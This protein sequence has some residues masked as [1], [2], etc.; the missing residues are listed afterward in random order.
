MAKRNT[1]TITD[2]SNLSDAIVEAN[3]VPENVQ[4]GMSEMQETVLAQAETEVVNAYNDGMLSLDEAN[5]KLALLGANPIVPV[6]EGWEYAE[7]SVSDTAAIPEKEEMT[8]EETGDVM[9]SLEELKARANPKHEL[10]I[11]V[12]DFQAMVRDREITAEQFAAIIGSEY[13]E[14]ELEPAIPDPNQETKSDD[15]I[16]GVG[17]NNPPADDDIVAEEMRETFSHWKPLQ[18]F[19][20]EEAHD[21]LL[22]VLS[23][24]LEHKSKGETS[25]RAEMASSIDDYF[26][27]NG[28]GIAKDSTNALHVTKNLYTDILKNVGE[29]F[30]KE[31]WDSSFSATVGVAIETAILMMVG[32]AKVGYFV[33][34]GDRKAVRHNDIANEAWP[35][36]NELAEGA[37]VIK[38]VCVPANI[39]APNTPNIPLGGELTWEVN[40]NTSLFLLSATIS[41]ALYQSLWDKGGRFEVDALNHGRITGFLSGAKV[42]EENAR[43]RAKAEAD[44]IAAEKRNADAAAAKLAEANG[45]PPA[46]STGETQERATGGEPAAAEAMSVSETTLSQ[47]I[48][49]ESVSKD[50]MATLRAGFEKVILERDK[51][52]RDNRNLTEAA[53]GNVLKYVPAL[54]Q[55]IRQYGP[56]IAV[57]TNVGIMQTAREMIL[58]C[59]FPKA[60]KPLDPAEI[61][62]AAE[63]KRMV[64]RLVVDTDDDKIIQ[65]NADGKPVDTFSGLNIAA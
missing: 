30:P 56:N 24:A 6:P 14:Q 63:L 3:A 13:V 37:R 11:P 58:R 43:K 4:D 60:D 61:K 64:D 59:L 31:D 12:E 35:D 53:A 34:P 1:K 40:T 55:A 36:P 45:T 28:E 42:A 47:L 27:F 10:H 48:A 49:K 33:L 2:L 54:F 18:A 50:D 46:T 22:S 21:E 41:K 7:T 29:L 65:Q 16:K 9:F 62:A 25:L 23:G 26:Y 19:T 5:N 44:R 39:L 38:G 32:K 20:K 52:L 8:V 51:L 17:H 15:E 57:T